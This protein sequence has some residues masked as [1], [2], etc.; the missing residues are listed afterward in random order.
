MTAEILRIT[1]YK[2]FKDTLRAELR[3]VEEG[4]IRIGYLLK[5]ARDTDIL[6]G[7][8]YKSLNEFARAEFDLNET[9]VNRF[10]NINDKYSVN[11]YSD[12]IKEEY[13]GYGWTKL[14]EML[15]LPEAVVKDI[16]PELTRNELRDIKEAI[17]EEDKITDIEV[18][19]EA[20]DKQVNGEDTGDILK[21]ALREVL[22]LH[23]DKFCEIRLIMTNEYEASVRERRRCDVL[24]SAG[25]M[26]YTV[27]IKGVGTVLFKCEADE[28]SLTNVRTNERRLYNWKDVEYAADYLTVYQD[29]PERV[30]EK[31]YGEAYPEEE[32]EE[33]APA[34]S[35][36]ETAHVSTSVK[37]EKEKKE[38]KKRQEARKASQDIQKNAIQSS[39][40]TKKTD[41]PA[42][43]ADG[44]VSEDSVESKVESEDSIEIDAGEVRQHKVKVRT[45]TETVELD[46]KEAKK[47]LEYG[48]YDIVAQKFE[49]I[50]Q[51]A[52]QISHSLEILIR[53]SKET[54]EDEKD[55]EDES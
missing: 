38:A 14:G 4:F 24:S 3:T 40:D 15:T 25:Y 30:W 26:L 5:Q 47:N 39:E 10:I 28:V 55:E 29:S 48:F 53:A 33:I 7:S 18:A 6:A 49:E 1:D 2:T 12:K 20:A 35:K 54:E 8:Q 36:K 46:L 42:E 44:A 31:I 52:K 37:K 34:Q 22:R 43:I 13:R 19:I 17:K 21:E 27:R 32:K 45:Y 50:G 11:G 23:P 51:L 9:V 16:R 41:E